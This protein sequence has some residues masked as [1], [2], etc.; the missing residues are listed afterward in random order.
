MHK[1]NLIV[2]KQDNTLAKCFSD[3][4]L[5]TYEKYRDISG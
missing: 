3:L 4:N 1:Q 5:K 2:Q